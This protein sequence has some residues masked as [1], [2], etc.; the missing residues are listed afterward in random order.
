MLTLRTFLPPLPIPNRCRRS[1]AWSAPSLSVPTVLAAL[2]VALSPAALAQEDAEDEDE[3][4]AAVEQADDEVEEVIVTGSRLKRSTYT[5]V[6]PLQIITGE[7]SRE[8]GLIDAGEILQESTAAGG[9]QIDLTFQGFVLDNGPGAVTVDLRGLG[10][11]RTLVLI[12]GRRMAPAGVEGAPSSPD[13]GLIPGLLVQQY[14]QLLD[15]ASSVYGSDAIAGVVK[16]HLVEG[17]RRLRVRGVPSISGPRR[18]QGQHLRCQM[19]PQL[20]PRLH[21]RRRTVR[22]CGSDHPGRPP[23]DR[24]LRP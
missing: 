8:A 13:L 22:G 2:C 16:R 12:N 21:R 9:V 17:L 1:A 24:R 20:R 19:G 14:D 23:L 18:G 7:V 6:S 10:A 4:A 11:D 5:S 15:G 3:E